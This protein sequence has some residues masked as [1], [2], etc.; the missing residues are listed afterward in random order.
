MRSRLLLGVCL[1]AGLA[2]PAYAQDT[3]DSVSNAFVV[4]TLKAMECQFSVQKSHVSIE[5]NDR[6]FELYRLDGGSR[7]LLKAKPRT[8]PSLTTVNK[9]NEHIAVTT[10]AVRYQKDGVVLESGLDCGLGL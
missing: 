10:R 1:L 4:N 3:V 5:L 9:Y 8:Q 7:V 6:K 2:A